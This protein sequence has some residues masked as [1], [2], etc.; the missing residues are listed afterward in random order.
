MNNFAYIVLCSILLTACGCDPSSPSPNEDGSVDM[1]DSGNPVDGGE[2]DGGMVDGNVNP[3]VD[4]GMAHP[5][6]DFGGI[7]ELPPDTVGANFEYAIWNNDV[8]YVDHAIADNATLA[9]YTLSAQ[10]IDDVFPTNYVINTNGQ[11][12]MLGLNNIENMTLTSDEDF[13]IEF[14]TLYGC[15]LNP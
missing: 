3:P 10:D 5:C 15:V 13:K 6:D 14:V 12:T 1:M 8:Y 11:M 2:T 7:V 9:N 4:S